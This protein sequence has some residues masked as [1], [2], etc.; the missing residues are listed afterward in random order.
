MIETQP[1]PDAIV[2][3][4]LALF[5]L[6]DAKAEADGLQEAIDADLAALVGLPDAMAM[7]VRQLR[8]EAEDHTARARAASAEAAKLQNYAG[9]L[10]EAMEMEMQSLG[11]MERAGTVFRWVREKQGGRDPLTLLA[12][13][14]EWPTRFQ[15]VSTAIT[16]DLMGIRAALEAGD[17]E[18]MAVASIDTTPRFVLKIK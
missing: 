4:L 16:P 17:E 9:A 13:T 3:R 6:R 18:A 15:R 5:E 11:Q 1:D 7:A 8:K 10:M 2:L 12:P 14:T